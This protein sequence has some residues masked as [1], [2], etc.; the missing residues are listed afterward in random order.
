MI[1]RLTTGWV[2]HRSEQVNTVD[3]RTGSRLGEPIEIDQVY[4]LVFY[5]LQVIPAG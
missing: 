1:W 2:E 3:P 4:R 5:R